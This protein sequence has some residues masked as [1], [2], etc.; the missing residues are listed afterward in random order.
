MGLATADALRAAGHTVVGVDLR[1]ADV[2]ADLSTVEGRRFASQE[3]LRRS[4]GRLDGAVL[5]AGLGPMPRRE[6]DIARVNY[7]GVVDLLAAW[8]AALAET[9]AAKVVVVGSNSTTVTPLVPR[10]S[11]RALLAGDPDRAVRAVRMFRTGAAPM[12]Y[13]ASKLAV[14]RWVRRTAVTPAWAGAGIRLNVL[15]PGAVRTPLLERQLDSPSARAVA[16]FPVPAGNYGD[17]ALLATWMTF[18]LSD[19]ADFLVGSVVLVDGGSDAYLRPD[20]WPR[21]VPAV[22]LVGYIRRMAAFRRRR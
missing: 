3:V 9:G 1:D 5:A 7:L 4:G 6:H 2:V 22:G 12:I 16:G 11:V 13:A 10:R 8:R 15:A 17:P 21:P 19:A 14:S 20:A 18:M